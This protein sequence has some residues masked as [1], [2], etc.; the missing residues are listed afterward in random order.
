MQ[1]CLLTNCL[2]RSGGTPAD[3]SDFVNPYLV[4]SPFLFSSSLFSFFFPPFFPLFLPFFSSSPCFTFST[5]PS[6]FS[7]CFFFLFQ[8]LVPLF[9]LLPHLRSL[10]HSNIYTV[11]WSFLSKKKNKK[12]KKNYDC[13][14]QA[15]PQ[16]SMVSSHRKQTGPCLIGW[17]S[18]VTALSQPALFFSTH[19]ENSLSRASLHSLIYKT[20]RRKICQNPE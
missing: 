3:F 10:F 11:L 13:Q 18:Q 9:L 17:F 8:P 4:L 19:S 1:R 6:P 5:Q 7:R 20:H 2:V 12:I 14:R 16:P 15:M